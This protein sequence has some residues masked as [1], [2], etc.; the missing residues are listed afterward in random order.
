MHR[1]L[2]KHLPPLPSLAPAGVPVAAED[3][4][5]L[6]QH[7]KT[8]RRL[9]CITGAGLSTHSGLPDYRS[10]RGSY[11]RGHV[12]IKHAEFVRE[13]NKRRRYWARSFVG[14]E[15][16][17]RAVPN[18]A[19]EALA[20][21][22]AH[23]Y[24]KGGC[25]TQNVDDLHRAAGQRDLVHLHG[26][27]DQVECLQC[28]ASSPRAALQERLKE[29]NTEWLEERGL[30]DGLPADMRA[31]GDVGLDDGLD[32][33]FAYPSCDKCGDGMLKPAV[34]FF[35]GAVPPEVSDRAA[36]MASD[37]DAC[38]IVGSSVQTY[39]AFRLVRA[40]AEAGRP[41]VILNIGPT[42]AD[43][44]STLRIESDAADVLPAVVGAVVE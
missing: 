2:A 43:D 19:H 22:E 32:V 21:L 41:V 5:A 28:G 26:R 11:S 36:S 40:V 17:S 29:A 35:G 18:P 15:F 10:P 3:L 23:G 1:S 20:S 42:R 25:I 13:A 37:A 44:L 12:P 30:A 7:V 24:L 4:A 16:F 9:L 6:V 38:L 27:I 33:G 34:V 31:D 14:W 8:A 39:S